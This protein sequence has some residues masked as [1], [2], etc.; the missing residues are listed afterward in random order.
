MIKNGKFGLE[1]ESQDFIPWDKQDPCLFGGDMKLSGGKTGIVSL[2]E[3]WP[4][5]LIPYTISASYSKCQQ[6]ELLNAISDF[7]SNEAPRQ[8]EIIASAMNALHQ[9][10]CIRFVPRASEK[11]YVR[12]TK[13]GG[14]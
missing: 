4:D 3:R 12:I 5:A 1:I 7:H 9:N 10:T 6:I 14:G 11:D 13:T 8:R 2:K